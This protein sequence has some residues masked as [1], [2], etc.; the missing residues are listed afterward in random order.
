MQ[1]MAQVSATQSEAAALASQAIDQCLT[2]IL[3]NESYGIDI[4]RVQEIRGWE[5]TTNLPGVPA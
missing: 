4:L 1:D 5:K 3:G 2:F